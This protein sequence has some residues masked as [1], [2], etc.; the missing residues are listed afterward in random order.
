MQNP[1]K[2]RLNCVLV[3]WLAIASAPV[4]CAQ[5]VQRWI[6]P[7]FAQIDSPLYEDESQYPAAL[8]ESD[9]FSFFVEDIA[10]L[11]YLAGGSGR[12][13]LAARI[14]IFKK[15]GTR[16]AIADKGPNGSYGDAWN[17]ANPNGHYCQ[18]VPCGTGPNQVDPYWLGE[19]SAQNTLWK[20]KPIYDAG[21][22]VSYISVDGAGLADTILNGHGPGGPSY[23]ANF[24][25]AD[26][27]AAFA[28]YIQH[29]HNGTIDL[30]GHSDIK[31]GIDIA[32]PNVKYQGTPS[33]TGSDSLNSLD[34]YDV[35]NAIVNAVEQ[36]GETLWYVHSDSPYNYTF[37]PYTDDHL[38][39]LIWLRNQCQGLGLRYGAIFNT[40]CGT[41]ECYSDETVDYIRKYRSRTNGQD[42]DD[43][44]IENWYSVPQATFPECS[45]SS[46]GCSSQYSFMNLVKKIATPTNDFFWGYD[47]RFSRQLDPDIFDW[48]AYLAHDQVLANWVTSTFGN[49]QRFGAEWHWLNF[50]VNEGRRGSGRFSARY[51]LATY[52]QIADV[53]GAQNYTGA[54]DH[55]FL[56]GRNEGRYGTD[57]NCP[58]S[59]WGCGGY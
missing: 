23:G 24:S 31:I 38:D 18:E 15:H 21:G 43:I 5:N 39:R 17:P 40:E 1:S 8:R 34:F 53:Y 10:N 20:I 6:H 50:G 22:T 26:S 2:L 44:V 32:M 46:P 25:L 45:D 14:Q 4:L 37:P 35:L 59:S 36:A 30:P 55:Y 51:Y 9:V 49:Q 33:P 56:F 16:I 48:Q 7:G 13:G 42:P 12:P 54:I 27:V 57:P 28:S 3:A 19:T 47:H 29:I 58:E 52:P 41:D 11:G